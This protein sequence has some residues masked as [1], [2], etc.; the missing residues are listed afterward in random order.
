[1]QKTYSKISWTYVDR[2]DFS[3]SEQSV[4]TEEVPRLLTNVVMNGPNDWQADTLTQREESWSSSTNALVNI[5]FLTMGLQQLEK[6]VIVSAHPFRTPQ[7]SSWHKERK[8][9]TWS[10]GKNVLRI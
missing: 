7:T 9:L 2:N 8:W 5:S 10:I 3:A 1:M 6:T 4:V